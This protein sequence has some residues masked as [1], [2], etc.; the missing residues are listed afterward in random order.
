MTIFDHWH[1]VEGKH[2]KAVWRQGESF[3]RYT[4]Q[5]LARK[6]FYTLLDSGVFT[7]IEASDRLLSMWSN[8]ML[9][10]FQWQLPTAFEAD[11]YASMA[12]V[13]YGLLDAARVRNP[14]D[15]DPGNPDNVHFRV[16]LQ[17]DLDSAK[18]E[19]E[20]FSAEALLERFG[21][22]GLE[23]LDCWLLAG[24]RVIRQNHWRKYLATGDL[25]ELAIAYASVTG[26]QKL[27]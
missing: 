23:S 5:R 9:T 2:V 20:Q 19:V 25:E 4:D 16:F 26:F 8:E 10:W 6:A 11:Y 24:Q 21:D 22:R 27:S 3:T 14:Q 17:R 1:K 18:F 12:R 15:F 7:S 13:Q